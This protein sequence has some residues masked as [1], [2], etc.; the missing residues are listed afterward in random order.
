[1]SCLSSCGFATVVYTAGN[2]AKFVSMLSATVVHTRVCM[3]ACLC[4]FL[5]G[6]FH[7][8][9]EDTQLLFFKN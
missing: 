2:C 5:L 1:M 8:F 4:V 3:C 9:L 7:V 6:D